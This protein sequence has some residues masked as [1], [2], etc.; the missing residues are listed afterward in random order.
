MRLEPALSRLFMGGSVGV[1]AKACRAWAARCHP[2]DRQ[3]GLAMPRPSH[4]DAAAGRSIEEDT[5]RPCMTCLAAIL[6]FSFPIKTNA[7]DFTARHGLTSAQ[8]QAAFNQYVGQGYRLVGVDGYATPNGTRYAAI[9]A[10][11]GGSPWV[12]RHGLSAGQYQAAFSQYKAQGYRPVELSATGY[13]QGSGNFAVLWDKSP[14]AWA[15]RHGLTSQQYQS[16]FN[17]YVKQGY[18]LVDIEGYTTQGGVVRYA[19]L[20]L[21]GQGP[22]W[23]ARHGLTPGQYQAAFKKAV[24]QGY[25]LVKVDGYWTPAGVRYA[26]T[27]ERR[28]GGRWVARHG[29]TS[30]QYQQAFNAYVGQ[31]YRLVHISGYTDGGQARFAAIWSQ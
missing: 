14:A 29:L 28:G 6:A 4:Q 1:E 20:W 16:A 18:R 19:A 22:A 2:Q 30:G 24:S 7:A 23:I 12:A 15:A 27:W 25:R 11:R 17:T 9:W 26:A 13:G 5:M 31:G 8:Y 21:R 10:R 3:H